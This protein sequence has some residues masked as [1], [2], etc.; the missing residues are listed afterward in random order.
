MNSFF[1][2]KRAVRMKPENDGLGYSVDRIQTVQLSLKDLK[3]MVGRAL[4]QDTASDQG[5]LS[6][7]FGELQDFISAL[8]EQVEDADDRLWGFEKELSKRVE[9]RER[10]LGTFQ[11][12]SSYLEAMG[13]V[14]E[15]EHQNAPTADPRDRLLSDLSQNVKSGQ[16]EAVKK[17]EQDIYHSTR[18]VLEF[19]TNP[20]FRTRTPLI[21]VTPELIKKTDY[22]MILALAREAR[23]DLVRRLESFRAKICAKEKLHA[24]LREM[25]AKPDST[26]SKFFLEQIAKKL[27]QI[28]ALLISP[29]AIPAALTRV[30]AQVRSETQRLYEHDRQNDLKRLERLKTE[31]AGLSAMVA[32]TKAEANLQ[33][34]AD[35]KR[36]NELEGLL[37]GQVEASKLFREKVVLEIG[38]I[39]SEA[40][41]KNNQTVATQAEA[42]S[43]DA[44]I[45]KLRVR[46]EALEVER[47]AANA[48]ATASEE[49]VQANQVSAGSVLVQLSAEHDKERQ[50]DQIKLRN[51]EALLKELNQKFQK[52]NDELVFVREQ[53]ELLEKENSER[54]KRLEKSN[55]QVINGKDVGIRKLRDA[56]MRLQKEVQVLTS[57]VSRL[58]D[59]LRLVNEARST[60]EQRAASL[61]SRL[62]RLELEFEKAVAISVQKKLLSLI[63]LGKS[64]QLSQPDFFRLL[65]A[66]M[67]ETVILKIARYVSSP[68]KLLTAPFEV[69]EEILSNNVLEAYFVETKMS[70]LE[71]REL[72][73]KLETLLLSFA[74]IHPPKGG[75]FDLTRMDI[76]DD[77]IEYLREHLSAGAF[78]D[79]MEKILQEFPGIF[80]NMIHLEWSLK[81]IENFRTVVSH[82]ILADVEDKLSPLLNER[83]VLM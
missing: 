69:M 43:K 12:E 63:S 24:Q 39:Q 72:E 58:S 55:E 31:K 21:E 74:K 34:F 42:R 62:E 11:E 38:K 50:E 51:A 9:E 46:M 83:R 71:G 10:K 23:E 27:D 1:L 35:K 33:K 2:P 65:S 68:G 52:K 4:K 15:V 19:V 77:A 60:A 67:P 3:E 45:T 6:S 57:E 28:S 18:R 26:A 70:F 32:H 54:M 7:F 22:E 79:L 66:I 25:F 41:Q 17:L 47:D 13:G 29:K 14:S 56:E 36:I 59:L 48:R 20:R 5:R 49:I 44:E 80:N 16:M 76:N 40:T 8:S 61:A 75:A 30:A 37:A 73:E 78:E 53:I 64:L 82:A 81:R